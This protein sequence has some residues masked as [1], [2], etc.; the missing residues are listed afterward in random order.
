MP[1]T[2]STALPSFS[3]DQHHETDA[4]SMT[5]STG[6]FREMLV[7]QVLTELAHEKF[8]VVYKI[9]GFIFFTCVYFFVC[10][11]MCCLCLRFYGPCCLK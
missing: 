4:A 2:T 5:D 7:A 10:V 11:C 9:I 3:D 6:L 8:E 1:G